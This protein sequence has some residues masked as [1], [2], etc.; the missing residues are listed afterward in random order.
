MDAVWTEKSNCYAY[1][2]NRPDIGWVNPGWVSRAFNRN[3]SPTT[4]NLID[5]Y[6]AAYKSDVKPGAKRLE[7]IAENYKKLLSEDGC[8]FLGLKYIPREKDKNLMFLVLLPSGGYHC[9]RYDGGG[10]WSSKNGTGE[11][12]EEY[13]QDG[14]STVDHFGKVKGIKKIVGFFRVP[15]DLGQLDTSAQLTLDLLRET[16][17]VECYAAYKA[18]KSNR[19]R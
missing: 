7:E 13:K 16:N 4:Q 11:V 8:D 12:Y 6:T 1:V 15:S 19:S 2:L 10:R 14:L 9:F 5:H 18:R 3:A 17:H